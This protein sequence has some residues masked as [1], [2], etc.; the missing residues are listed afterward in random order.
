MSSGI[1]QL[2]KIVKE[3]SDKVYQPAYGN[4]VTLL[5]A[6]NTDAWS[7]VVITICNPGDGVL[8]SK[9]TYPRYSS[10]GQTIIKPADSYLPAR[11]QQC[12]R[13]ISSLFQLI[14]MA[15]ECAAMR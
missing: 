5:H 9:W 4:Y 1:P 12:S 2:Q 3:F 11:W 7:K 10:H 6:G 8:V 14:L 15:R 13:T